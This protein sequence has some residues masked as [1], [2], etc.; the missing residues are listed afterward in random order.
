MIINKEIFCS[1]VVWWGR[2]KIYIP[3][4]LHSCIL[5]LAW[6]ILRTHIFVSSDPSPA[7]KDLALWFG[8]WKMLIEYNVRWMYVNERCTWLKPRR[9]EDGRRKLWND[10]V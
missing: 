6:T 8:I 1:N 4:N 3:D 9:P 2:G 7:L 10:W 5:H